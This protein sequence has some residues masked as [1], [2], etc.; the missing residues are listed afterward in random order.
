MSKGRGT[1]I[2]M[3]KIKMRFQIA[4]AKHGILKEANGPGDYRKHLM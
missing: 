3:Q 1:E 4:G 2:G